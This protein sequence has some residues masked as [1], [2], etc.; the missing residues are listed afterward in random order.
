MG[1]NYKVNNIN[2]FHDLFSPVNSFR[3]EKIVQ[4]PLMVLHSYLKTIRCR[5]SKIKTCCSQN[6][7]NFVRK[8]I[9]QFF[10]SI[11]L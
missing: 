8:I 7:Q 1:N 10:S 6:F 2:K 3:T 4:D 11:I 5:T 9:F